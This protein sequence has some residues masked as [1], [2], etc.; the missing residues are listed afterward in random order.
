MNVSTLK[1]A[2]LYSTHEPC[3]MCS[4]AI[5][6]YKISKVVFQNTVPYLGGVSSSMPLLISEDVPES[7]GEAPEIM[8]YST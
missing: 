4:Y 8:H 6:Y 3:V 2:T 7:W 1:G 5:R